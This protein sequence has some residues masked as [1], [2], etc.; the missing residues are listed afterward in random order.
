M[1]TWPK[2]PAIYQSNTR[3]R[4]TVLSQ[5]LDRLDASPGNRRA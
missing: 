2:T 3:V 4:L 5:R 1:T